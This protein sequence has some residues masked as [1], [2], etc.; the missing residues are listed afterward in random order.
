LIPQA[1]NHVLSEPAY[2]NPEIMEM[3]AGGS[4]VGAPHGTHG[5][6][7]GVFPAAAPESSVARGRIAFRQI[8]WQG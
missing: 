6:R 3:V 8:P 5:F 1:S 7:M 4:G 2:F